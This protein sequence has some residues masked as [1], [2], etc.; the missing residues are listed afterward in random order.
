MCGLIL[1][2]IG[3]CE[4]KNEIKEEQKVEKKIK[5]ENQPKIMK[6]YNPT[7]PRKLEPLFNILY[8]RYF[9][10]W[11]ISIIPNDFK[12]TKNAS[13]KTFPKLRIQN[14]FNSGN[15]ACPNS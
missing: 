4:N 11:L 3:C 12:E 8:L 2:S 15:I 13:H 5:K 1:L 7:D 14:S 6:I 10:F 9:T